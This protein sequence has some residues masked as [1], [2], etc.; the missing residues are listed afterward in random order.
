[1]ESTALSPL[2]RSDPVRT[3]VFNGRNTSKN[4]GD[5]ATVGS[6]YDSFLLLLENMLKTKTLS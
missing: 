6:F 3:K 1:M 2:R 5:V 4:R